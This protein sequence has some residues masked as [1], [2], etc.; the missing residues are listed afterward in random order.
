ML[1]H[2]LRLLLLSIAK[3]A[4]SSLNT[5]LSEIQKSD[6]ANVKLLK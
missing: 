5:I 1:Q 4:N 3:N 2:I 6:A